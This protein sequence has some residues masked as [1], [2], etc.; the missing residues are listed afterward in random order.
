MG[1]SNPY[2][3]Q[4]EAKTATEPFTVSFRLPDETLD[5]QVDPSKIPYGP[6]GQP[7]SLLDIAMGAGLDVEHACGGVCACSTCHVIVKEGLDSC[8][9]ATDDELDQLDEAPAI[10]LQSRL[11][12]QCVPDGSTNLIVEIPEWNKNLVK[13][14][15]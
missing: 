9:E 5:V 1:G 2:I 12:C 3:E 11:A 8:S 7:G 6:T 10:T 13:E 14:G 4:V 15:H